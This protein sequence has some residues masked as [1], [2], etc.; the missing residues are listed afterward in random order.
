MEWLL[1]QLKSLGMTLG[2]RLVSA[3]LVFVIG[4]K[5]VN[6][7][8][9][10]IKSG[11]VPKNIDLS[12][13]SFIGSFIS[14]ALKLVIIVSVIAIMGVPMSSVVALVASAGV[15]IGL[16]VQGALSNL[17]GGI[18]IL[19]F[20]P[21]K[22]GDYIEAQG[23]GGTVREITVFYTVL[24]TPDNKIITVPNG[25]LTNSVVVNY[26]VEELRRVDV[27]IFADYDNDTEMVK[28]TILEVASLCEKALDDPEK[29]VV[30]ADCGDKGI[31][32]SLRVWSKNADYWD[33]KFYLV[34][35]IRNAFK[36]ANIEIPVPQM[37]VRIKKD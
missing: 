35:G 14:I 24:C 5:I 30:I 9:K 3:I 15:A 34:E 2:I 7:L 27:E 18:M 31:K 20:R 32:Y 36:E 25:G 1:E 33:V 16:A 37:D 11:K 23:T 6:V 22:V 28:K 19:L 17:V 12:A 26:S 13:A 8:V 10:R 29:T 4:F 21:F